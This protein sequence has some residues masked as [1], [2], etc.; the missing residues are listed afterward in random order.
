MERL[1]IWGKVVEGMGKVS[2]ML[3]CGAVRNL[4]GQYQWR[5]SVGAAP[6]LPVKLAFYGSAIVLKLNADITHGHKMNAGLST[7]HPLKEAMRCR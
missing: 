3:Q 6:Y 1:S 4:V 2:G 5:L 7:Q